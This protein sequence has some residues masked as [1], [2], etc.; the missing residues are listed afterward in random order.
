M[1]LEVPRRSTG[2]WPPETPP[3]QT[4]CPSVG[5]PTVGSWLCER[6]DAGGRGAVRHHCHRVRDLAGG[7]TQHVGQRAYLGGRDS[8]VGVPGDPHG[9]PR[10]GEGSSPL[11]GPAPCRGTRLPHRRGGP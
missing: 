10:G 3:E 2:A 1:I 4:S 6:I 9:A 7:S 11:G 5:V 8:V